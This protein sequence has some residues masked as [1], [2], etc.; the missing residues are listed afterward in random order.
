MPI[1]VNTIVSRLKADLDAEGSERY[2]F[3]QDFKY[4]INSGMETLIALFNDAF[5]KK[6][7]TPE[8]LRELTKI[9]IWQ[10]SKYSRV[11]Y[12]V[13]DIGHPFWTI[14]GVYPKPTVNKGVSSVSLPNS[15]DSKFRDD[16]SFVSSNH[17]AKRM[18]FEQWSQRRK[19]VFMAGN[20]ILKGELLEYAYLDPMDYSSAS[21][22]TS[23]EIEIGPEIPNELVAI[24]YLKYPTQ[25]SLITDSIEFPESLTDLISEIALNAISVKQGDGTSAYA[26]SERNVTK[27]VNLI[28]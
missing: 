13:N 8:S 19:N 22:N 16:L 17:S 3:D 12:N 23:I 11:N 5:A 4:A 9:K 10:T 26:V 2:T 20:N 1:L 21:Y 28:K 24:A 27:L 25:I 15:D 18:N 14:F 6:K 7:L